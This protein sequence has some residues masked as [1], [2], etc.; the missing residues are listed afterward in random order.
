MP[1]V[2]TLLFVLFCGLNY[3]SP[4]ADLDWSWQ[5]RTGEQ[6]VRTRSLRVADEFTYT[7]A[8]KPLQDFE[9]LYEVLLY[10]TWSA[11]GMGGLK[12]LRVLFVAA[13]LW[14][15][16]QRLRQE[17]FAWHGI[18][19]TL[20]LCF[21]VLAQ[22][23][24]L[25]PM[26]VTTIGLLLVS[27]WLHDH[28]TRGR[29]LDW[30]LPVVMLIWANGHPGVI[31]GQGMLA[32]AIGWEWFN[33]F[34]KWNTPLERDR[35]WRLAAFA[36]LGLAASFVC[37][38]PLERIRYTFKPELAH[39]I[40]REFVE[41]LPLW[42]SLRTQPMVVLP[43]YLVAFAV[44]TTI[45]LRPRSWRVWELVVLA[46]LGV[47]GNVATRSM[48]DWHL[49]M[50]SLGLPHI[51]TLWLSAIAT[52][53]RRTWV[54]RLLS[55]DNIAKRLFASRIFRWQPRWAFGVLGILGILT[56]LPYPGRTMP[57][58]D[59]AEWPSGAMDFAAK[60]QL[61][62]NYFAP[63]D[64]G[65]YV[66]WRL[67]NTGKAYV[68]T[69]GFFFPPMLLEDSIYLPRMHA[70]WH[71]RLDRVLAHGTDYFLLETTGSRGRMWEMLRPYLN[72]PLYVDDQSAL[73][74]AADVKQAAERL[75][76]A[77]R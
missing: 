28:C 23:W 69:R 58:A 9:W 4:L 21:V 20:L 64:Y 10:G 39:P 68:D 63:P 1:N 71:E 61:A 35:L 19:L 55:L 34:V 11:F 41:M 18:A 17:N 22:A 77:S 53:A 3:F 48:P 13:P 24:N 49:V 62:G 47:L 46:A 52:D 45:I 32:A 6:I 44:L 36:G 59:A 54:R 67:K 74:T 7:I 75:A 56:A 40:H 27:G 15:L 73:L 65:A 37:P 43:V 31:A 30:K 5:V 50:L 76:H 33:R 70:D 38:D 51:R 26:L 12:L 8:D 66:G 16:A 57:I 60:Q 25:R 72:E 14:I 29:Q 42:I 2:A